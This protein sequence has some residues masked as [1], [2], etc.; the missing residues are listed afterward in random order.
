M[1]TWS[2]SGKAQKILK[3]ITKLLLIFFYQD[4]LGGSFEKQQSLSGILSNINIWSRIL[5]DDEVE[6]MSNCF[7]SPMGDI[8]DWNKEEKNWKLSNVAKVDLDT[9]DFCIDFPDKNYYMLPERRSL[10]SGQFA[11]EI[12]GGSVSFPLD[13]AENNAISKIGDDVSIFL[14]K[15][16]Q[17]NVKFVRHFKNV[18]TYLIIVLSN[19]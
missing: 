16:F 7:D 4:T 10:E 11:C 8:F 5:T 9:S 19:L 3:N 18:S 17:S 12:M 2:R 15:F 1:D 14:K 6:R 13:K